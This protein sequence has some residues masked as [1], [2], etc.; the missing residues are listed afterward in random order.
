[1]DSVV[2]MRF[3][4]Y[5]YDI[6]RR[7]RRLAAVVLGS[8]LALALLGGGFSCRAAG[9]DRY[10]WLT[11]SAG[12]ESDRV[13]DPNLGVFSVPGGNFVN[14]TPGLTLTRRFDS[15]TRLTLNGQ[16]THEQFQNGADRTLLSAALAGD[17]R[18]QVRG[19]FQ[20]R[21]TLGGNY[22]SDSAQETVNRLSGGLKGAIGYVRS[23][24]YLDLVGGIQGRRYEN[25]IIQDASGLH[26]TYTE[27]TFSMGVEG[28]VQP[29]GL[30]VLTGLVTRQT[31][32]ARDPLFDSNSWLFQ[33][34][35]RTRVLPRTWFTANVFIQERR[36]TLRDP[37]IDTDSYRQIGTGLE[38]V[39]TGSLDVGVHYVFG[40]YT[41][42]S[43]ADE[44]LHRFS[45][46][47]TWW[48][49]R[50]PRQAPPIELPS[51]VEGDRVVASSNDSHLFRIHAPGARRVEL[52]A[53]FNNWDPSVNPLRPTADGWWE[54][55]L[56]LPAGV[57]QY[58]YLVDGKMV[59]P[60]DADV[61]VD[62]GFGGN[63]GL[64]KVFPNGS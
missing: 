59:T 60:P 53:D 62:D 32:D 52:V 7:P 12:Y 33:G 26:E 34:S 20:L 27:G 50:S 44:D 63:N 39:L 45:A 61:T 22:Y 25:L 51:D 48:I 35:A 29:F 57:Y 30:A 64:L 40:R 28:A 14:L 41:Q 43:G 5:L 17:L 37:G 4:T 38:H 21:A 3:S 2:K 11:V 47:I 56:R 8:F 55:A 16:L 42:T 46:G 15:R 36:F 10:S 24:W 18:R 13:L 19:P 31:T 54:L 49:G 23:W 1:M 9:W 6:C 58:S